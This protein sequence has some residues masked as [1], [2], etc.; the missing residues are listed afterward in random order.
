MVIDGYTI[1][2]HDETLVDRSGLVAGDEVELWFIC[3]TAESVILSAKAY[4]DSMEAGNQ[5]A[6]IFLAGGICTILPGKSTFTLTRRFYIYVDAMDDLIAAWEIKSGDGRLF[7]ALL[8][9]ES[10]KK[11]VGQEI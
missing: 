9:I 3:T 5:V 4:M 6:E 2:P 7:Y 8:V 11:P 1:P 10:F